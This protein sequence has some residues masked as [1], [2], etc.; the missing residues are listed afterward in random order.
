MSLDS[1]FETVINAQGFP[2]V[3]RK[4]E[5]FAKAV[6]QAAPENVRGMYRD[7]DMGAQR[8]TATPSLTSPLPLTL[9][10]FQITQRAAKRR[11]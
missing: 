5:K 7:E 4:G 6:P 10:S 2:V 1:A 3:V 8:V 9:S 11:V